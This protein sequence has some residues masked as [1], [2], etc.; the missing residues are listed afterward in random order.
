MTRF[1][2]VFSIALALAVVAGIALAAGL[3]WLAWQALRWALGPGFG[4]ACLLAVGLLA[5][6]VVIGRRL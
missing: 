1:E 5:G 4:I 3:C 6:R 2:I